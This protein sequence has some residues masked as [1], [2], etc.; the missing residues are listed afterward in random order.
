MIIRNKKG[1]FTLIPLEDRFWDKVE[2]TSS[3]WVWKSSKFSNGYGSIKFDGKY[4]LAHRVSYQLSGRKLI[5]N[6]VIMHICDNRACVNPDHLRS[7]TQ[8]DNLE[9]MRRKGRG[10][11]SYEIARI[12]EDNPAAKL[13]REDVVF[14]RKNYIPRVHTHKMLAQRFNVSIALIEKIIRGGVWKTI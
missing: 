12:G 6:K 10:P 13:K 7:G 1:Q 8:A 9:D 14:I 5:K 3:C 2:K 4:M 11:R